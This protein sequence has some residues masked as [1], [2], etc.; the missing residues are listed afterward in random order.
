LTLSKLYI[1]NIAFS[2]FMYLQYSKLF[3]VFQV[4]NEDIDMSYV[5]LYI[6]YT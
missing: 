5:A 6:I 3:R 1:D 2:C 4:T